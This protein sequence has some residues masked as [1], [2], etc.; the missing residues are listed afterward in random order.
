[1][2]SKAGLD[3]VEK[4]K[5]LILPGLELRP[6][7]P[8]ARSRL[9]ALS[10][11]TGTRKFEVNAIETEAKDLST[12]LRHFGNFIAIL[13]IFHS[14]LFAKFVLVRFRIYSAAILRFRFL[15]VRSVCTALDSDGLWL[16]FTRTRVT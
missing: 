4:R 14:C 13:F 16:P 2:D 6:L 5:F 12:V 15:E 3:D 1:V 11:Y 8:Q 7:R 10:G 9:T